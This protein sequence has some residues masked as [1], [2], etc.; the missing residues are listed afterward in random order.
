MRISLHTRQ[1]CVLFSLRIRCVTFLI[2]SEKN[3]GSDWLLK[4][5]KTARIHK[6]A[7]L[8]ELPLRTIENR[9]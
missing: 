6:S 9:E 8:S 2:A 1:T 4:A 3:T 5:N 7:P